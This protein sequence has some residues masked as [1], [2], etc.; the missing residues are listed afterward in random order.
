M[1]ILYFIDAPQPGGATN[2]LYTLLKHLDKNKFTPLVAFG[3]FPE[4]NPWI[5]S[6]KELNITT[7]KTRLTNFNKLDAVKEFK[8][9]FKSADPQIIHLHLCHSGS[10]R[11]AFLAARMSH[12]KIIATEHDPF[13][14][15]IFKKQVKRFT[16]RSTDHTIAVSE[17]NRNFL[18]EAYGIRGSKI[19]RIYN[20]VDLETYHPGT[21]SKNAVLG[22]D[23][24]N[25]VITT[26][27]ELHPRKGI[28]YLIKA[29]PKLVEKISNVKLV[30]VG[31]GKARGDYEKLVKDMGLENKIKFLG[32]K[33]NI[34]D[35]LRASNVF[36][37]PS[38]REAFGLA[39]VEAMAT[40]I[41]VV[42]SNI[43][44]LQE[45]LTKETGFMLKAKDSEAI[46]NAI[47]EIHDNPEFAK[48]LTEKAFER[49]KKE[50]SAEN[51]TRATEEIYKKVIN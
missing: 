15:N 11:A 27:A 9:L 26:A 38:V 17:N 20:G 4:L 18:T 50:F 47:L 14:L 21:V 31:T 36:V 16:L 39:I 12:A 8:R 51:M 5:K 13:K 7:L 19:T 30:I 49:V 37:L 40:K 2:Q 41:P 22:L 45:I 32:F 28:N 46:A 24:N 29:M 1:K 23:T 43:G 6:L 35:I 44:G 10:L 3:D 48:A 33:E 34:P 25:F 42:A